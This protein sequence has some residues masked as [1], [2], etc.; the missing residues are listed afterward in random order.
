MK[1][2]RIS[3]RDSRERAVQILF[4]LDINKIDDIAEYLKDY[5]KEIYKLLT[6]DKYLLELL[7][8]ILKKQKEIDDVIDEKLEFSIKSLDKVVLSV[9]RLGVYEILFEK[10]DKPL[11]I[12]EAINIIKK[13]GSS[14]NI[15]FVNAILDSVD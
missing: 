3:R 10:L 14:E 9:L 8:G 2:T 15:K 1:K 13:Y 12:S 5:Q 6:E 7:D 11:V 4:S